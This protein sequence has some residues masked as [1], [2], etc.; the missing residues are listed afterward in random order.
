MLYNKHNYMAYHI[1]NFG[2]DVGW[3]VHFWQIKTPYKSIT[4]FLYVI[5]WTRMFIFKF[6]NCNLS[7]PNVH[8]LM[9][10]L[11]PRSKHISKVTNV[12]YHGGCHLEILKRIPIKFIWMKANVN[13]LKTCSL[14][15]FFEKKHKIHFN[16][17]FENLIQFWPQ[18][19]I[20]TILLMF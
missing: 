19:S 12:I 8:P 5:K 16:K 13:I 3:M 15:T 9:K 10:P 2:V 7:L 17:T 20:T 4:Y 1:W 11:K 6:H 18:K 14:S